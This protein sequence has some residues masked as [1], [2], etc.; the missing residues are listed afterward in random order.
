[1]IT[2][3]RPDSSATKTEVVDVVNGERAV[4]ILLTS[5][6]KIMV[7]WV[8]TS[9]EHLLYVVATLLVHDYQSHVTN[10]PILDGKQFASM[11]EKRADILLESCTRTSS[12]LFGGYGGSSS[13]KTT[14][15]ISIDG[16]VE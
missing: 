1:M 6:W 3:G 15:L 4:L 2:T 10:T 9:M 14:E 11:K 12:M 5:L 13:S 8:P 16:G 7:L